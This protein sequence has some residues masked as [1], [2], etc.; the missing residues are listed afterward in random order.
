VSKDDELSPE[1]LLG[2]CLIFAPISVLLRPWVVMKLW[3]WFA[4]PH[5]AASMS[6]WF[7]MGVVIIVDI[8]YGRIPS[9]RTLNEYAGAW[10]CHVLTSGFVLAFGAYWQWMLTS[11]HP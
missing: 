11:F 5:G 7:W 6:Y 9:E 1:W 4:I 3:E 10:F 8:M 2:I